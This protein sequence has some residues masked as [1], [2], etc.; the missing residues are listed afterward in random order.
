[1]GRAGN[2]TTGSASTRTTACQP[3]PTISDGVGL[4]LALRRQEPG[5]SPGFRAN[6]PAESHVMRLRTY[7]TPRFHLDGVRAKRRGSKHLP[8]FDPG[9]GVVESTSSNVSHSLRKRVADGKH[10]FESR[11]GHQIV[12]VDVLRSG[13][14]ELRKVLQT[15]SRVFSSV[16]Q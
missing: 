2:D 8:N 10:G 15:R 6:V 14:E 3:I 13:F 5:P 12:F 9:G 11:W 4:D 7:R 16:H 1:M